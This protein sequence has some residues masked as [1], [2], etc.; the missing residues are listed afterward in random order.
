MFCGGGQTV[1]AHRLSVGFSVNIWGDSKNASLLTGSSAATG[2]S[3]FQNLFQHVL[4]FWS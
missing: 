1:K 2:K 3:S 4:E